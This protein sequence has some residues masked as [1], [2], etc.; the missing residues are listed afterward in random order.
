MS[1]KYY[2]IGDFHLEDGNKT[3]PAYNYRDQ[4][5]D[6]VKEYSSLGYTCISIGDFIDLWAREDTKIWYKNEDFFQELGKYRFIIVPGNHDRDLKDKNY[7]FRIRLEQ[8]GIIIEHHMIYRDTIVFCHG[9]YGDPFNHEYWKL[10]KLFTQY[11][12]NLEELGIYFQIR[13]ILY[14][15]NKINEEAYT[16]ALVKN[17][18]LNY[19]VM[20][21]THNYKVTDK[22][23]DTG[24]YALD[25][26]WLIET[27]IDKIR[28]INKK[29]NIDR[30]ITKRYP[31]EISS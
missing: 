30:T 29:R 24:F 28:I 2:V 23:L 16:V 11:K 5:L 13:N 19:C 4:L 3:D 22:Y 6:E 18:D 14:K 17:P 1:G 10:G 27:T 21:H 9:H 25:G 26:Y 15:G 12:E 31:V 20:G 7:W 8:L